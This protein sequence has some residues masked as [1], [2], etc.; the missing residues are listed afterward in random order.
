MPTQKEID[1]KLQEQA[2]EDQIGIRAAATPLPGATREA[3]AIVPPIKI[4]EF[5]VRRF[6]DGDIENLQTTGNAFG[7]LV[8]A[9]MSG[10][11]EEKQFVPRGKDAWELCWMMTRDIDEV[12]EVLAK[13]GVKG[14][15]AAAR[16]IFRKHQMGDLAV[17]VQA[18]ITQFGIYSAPVLGYGVKEKKRRVRKAA[19]QRHNLGCTGRLRLAFGKT[20]S[21]HVNIRAVRAFCEKQTGRRKRLGLCELGARKQHRIFRHKR[22]KNNARLHQARGRKNQSQTQKIRRVSHNDT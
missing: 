22:R 5:S 7:E 4:G 13:D 11:K 20:V 10:S 19:P 3:F 2:D 9:V 15:T 12:D 1:A 21:H 6:V 17:I 14:I 18:V 16:K 8:Q